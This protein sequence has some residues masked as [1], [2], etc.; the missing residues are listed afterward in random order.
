MGKT[1]KGW[2]EMMREGGNMDRGDGIAGA[3]TWGNCRIYQ[4]WITHG[5]FPC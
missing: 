1:W 3:S 4:L 2:A 5:F